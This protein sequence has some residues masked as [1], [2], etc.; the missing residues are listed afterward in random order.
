MFE[1]IRPYD[2]NRAPRSLQR[3]IARLGLYE[4]NLELF[5][6][7]TEREPARRPRGY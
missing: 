2:V 6:N 7:L 5:L 1:A 4:A 3:R